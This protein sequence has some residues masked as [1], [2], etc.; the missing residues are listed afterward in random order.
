V[1]SALAADTVRRAAARPHWRESYVGT[2]TDDG[3]VLEGFVDLVYREDDGAL[4]VVD[5]KTDAVP[6]A[7]LGSRDA[8]YRPQMEAYAKALAAGTGE[9]T[10]AELLYLAP[11]GAIARRLQ[12]LP[13]LSS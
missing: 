9:P 1:R 2:V 4:V 10:R 8:Y 12:D 13:V 6:E 7:G 3:T 11:H 5:Y